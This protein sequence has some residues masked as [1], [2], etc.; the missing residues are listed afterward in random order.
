MA[1]VK[2][3]EVRLLDSIKSGMV[4]FYTPQASHETMLAQ[5]PASTIDDLFVHHFQTDQLLVVRGSFVLVIL[6]NREYH[7]IPLSD[8]QPKVVTIPPGIPHGAINLSQEP[9]LLVNAVLRHGPTYEKDY[10]PLRKPFPF[11]I[12]K[13]RTLLTELALPVTA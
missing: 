12:A 1:L 11:D 13:A 8:R 4:E 5:I 2:Q 3:V 6:Q 7:Y 10:R 9:C